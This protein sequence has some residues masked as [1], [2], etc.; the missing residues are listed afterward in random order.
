MTKAAEQAEK[1]AREKQDASHAG[2]ANYYR[3][4]V[5]W[6]KGDWDEVKRYADDKY[7]KMTG[8]DEVLQR[9]LKNKGQTYKEAYAQK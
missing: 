6:L 5:A 2:D 1:L 7:V 3:G 4:T 8:N 9:L